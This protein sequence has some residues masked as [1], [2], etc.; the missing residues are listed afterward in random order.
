MVKA[1]ANEPAVHRSAALAGDSTLTFSAS[2]IVGDAIQALEPDGF[3]VGTANT[4]NGVRTTYYWMAF[5]TAS[6]AGPPTALAIAAVNAGSH[7][8][9]GAGF[10]VLVQA[11]D[12]AG[13]GRSVTSAT[14]VSVSLKTGSGLLRGTL[15]GTIPAGASQVAIGGATYTKAESGVVLT[16]SRT[17]GDALAPGDSAPFTVDPGAIARYAVALAS[18]QTAG[19]AFAVSA[20]AEDQFANPV[21]TDSST[22]VT[23]GS[24]SGRVLFDGNA[25][26]TYG[27]ATRALRAG[28]ASVNAR[29][30][31][32]ETTAV[33]ATDGGGKTGSA[34]LT[35]TS[36]AAAMLAFTIQPAG[37]PV[38]TPLPAPPT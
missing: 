10:P 6:S 8:S 20:T 4:V 28:I 25:D 36:G 1:S 30:T 12:A 24:A 29:S 23:F 26:G 9:A 27:D 13:I 18:P 3:Q 7:P 34:P 5:R 37:A 31:N 22:R 35:V 14:A 2:A 15:T 16:A 21:T 32:A 11:R 38:G 17:G 19:T 33:I